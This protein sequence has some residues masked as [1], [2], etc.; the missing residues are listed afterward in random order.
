MRKNL[1]E[2]IHITLFDTIDDLKV[3]GKVLLEGLLSE[4]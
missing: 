4:D 1:L 2:L 3:G